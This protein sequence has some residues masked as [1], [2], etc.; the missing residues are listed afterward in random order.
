MGTIR[1]KVDP[2]KAAMLGRIQSGEQPVDVGDEHVAALSPEQR[3]MLS[4]LLTET[5]RGL[6]L[7]R[8]PGYS[9]LA[10]LPAATWEGI[11]AHL[12]AQIAAS[13]V[14]AEE[15]KREV[16]ERQ[17]QREKR[18]QQILA[19]WH[20]VLTDGYV[21]GYASRVIASDYHGAYDDP[22]IAEQ[23]Q[24]ARDE[25][26]RCATETR[27]YIVRWAAEK[28]AQEEAEE[29][30]RADWIAAHGSERLRRAVRLGLADSIDE[31]YLEER[32]AM[33]RP[34]W[35]PE[36]QREERGTAIEPSDE[37]LT[38]LEAARAQWR[39]CTLVW[40]KTPRR[41]GCEALGDTHLGSLVV[42]EVRGGRDTRHDE[43]EY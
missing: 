31:S 39:N 11:I 21:D 5:P 4:R 7:S 40:L 43:E 25:A 35:R 34:G 20:S 8:A 23:L 13:G 22:R 9:S 19:D 1:V 26:D 3:Q 41:G 17:E 29:K 32:L 38:A 24:R 16:Q 14:G 30:E 15:M 6:A 42:C 18:V 36:L 37:A 28:A 10:E 12:D 2:S 33:E 27:E